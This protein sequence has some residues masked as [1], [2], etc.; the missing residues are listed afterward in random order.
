MKFINKIHTY[1]S[2]KNARTI[3][4]I[5]NIGFSFA[6]KGFSILISFLL[7]PLTLDYLNAYEYGVWLTLNSVLS[8]IFLL[9]IGL[10]NGLKNKLSEAIA[11]NDT[12]N[13]KIYVSTT[14]FIMIGLFIFSFLIFL[15][16][17]S[18]INW[19]DILG[20]EEGKIKSLNC[21][22]LFVSFFVCLHFVTKI[23]GNIYQALQRSS[24]NDLIAFLG[25]TIS[26]IAIYILTKTTD[27]SL[28]YVG[29]TFSSI[30]VLIALLAMPVTFKKYPNLTPH[31]RY[32]RFSK[33]KDLASLGVSFFII[34]ISCVVL[35]TTSNIIISKLFGPDEVTPYN[36]ATKYYSA[37]TFIFNII[38]SP[39]WIATT[40]AYKRN[41][42]FWIKKMLKSIFYI[43]CI[44]VLIIVAM[45]IISPY[46]FPIWVGNKVQISS[47]ITLWSGIYIM[48]LTLS[49]V[50]ATF[51]NGFGKLRIQLIFSI[52]QPIIYIPLAMF[53][54]QHFGVHGILIALCI[55]CSIS[56]LW[57]PRQC[58]LLLTDKAYGYWNK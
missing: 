35:F 8:W 13:E 56:L 20:V 9:D 17:H 31:F 3:L 27:G 44:M 52:F 1:L 34:Q 32:I 22:V 21:I 14:L 24:V 43:W 15:I 48:I 36:I 11:T 26:L 45:Y 50:F 51:I 5:K 57:S 19:S 40:D 39:I 55:V 7:I 6:Y 18:F 58:W 42:L 53:C 30:P 16:M 38:L 28:F 54:G 4:V 46:L 10:G 41:D 47:S 37:L 25:N 23:V 2:K 49:N 33:I 12:E 29:I